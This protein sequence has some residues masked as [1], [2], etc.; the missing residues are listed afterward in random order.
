MRCKLEC[1]GKVTNVTDTN[2]SFSPGKECGRDAGNKSC[3]KFSLMTDPQH[4]SGGISSDG[5]TV[6]SKKTRGFRLVQNPIVNALILVLK[7]D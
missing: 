4:D 1:G 6:Y 2:I 3:L 7:R 5:S